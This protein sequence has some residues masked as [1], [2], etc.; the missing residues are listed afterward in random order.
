VSTPPP[1]DGRPRF[2]L[3]RNMGTIAVPAG[4]R[5][6]GVEVVTLSERYGAQAG[7]RVEDVQW[8][9]EAAAAGEAVLMADDAIRRKNPEERR[10]LIESELRALVIN[11]QLPAPNTIERF[12]FNLS[13]IVRACSRPGPFV[14]RI[15]PE[16]IERLRIPG[17]Y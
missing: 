10:V 12:S 14:Y 9:P 3:D 7:E 15:H 1:S 16:R 13:A 8:M 2:F 4:L 17:T 5:A 11:A 6:L